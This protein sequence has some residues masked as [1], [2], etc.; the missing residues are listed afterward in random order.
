MTDHS[1]EEED[2]HH[3]D[4]SGSVS[5]SGGNSEKQLI[6]GNPQNYSNNNDNRVQKSD[7][8]RSY[9]PK[10]STSGSWWRCEVQG[11]V[12][13]AVLSLESGMR[14]SQI[15]LQRALRT[16]SIHPK[17]IKLLIHAHD[18]ERSKHGGFSKRKR[19]SRFKLTKSLIRNIHQ[20]EES[21]TNDEHR[22]TRCSRE[23]LPLCASE[24]RVLGPGHR[25]VLFPPS[26][27]LNLFWKRELAQAKFQ[28]NK[29]ALNTSQTGGG[30]RKENALRT[31]SKYYTWD[32]N[33]DYETI[34]ATK[35]DVYRT[36]R[37][38]EAG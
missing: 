10:S 18:L 30:R 23:L 4:D 9:A 8:F 28:R 7:P 6:P 12:A 19:L 15:L 14:R 13:S 3:G 36:I 37:M 34:A 2:P 21:K 26:A 38:A 20:P 5:R 1:D 29:F 27:R 17:D 33:L 22:V 31:K 35:K 24:S 25:H 32:Y 16:A 11:T